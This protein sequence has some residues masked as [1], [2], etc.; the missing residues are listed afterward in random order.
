MSRRAAGPAAKNG[1]FAMT[2]IAGFIIAIVAG[3]I[4][5]D[6]RRAAAT[7]IIPWVAVLA[8]QTWI[9][10]AGRAVSPPGTVSHLPQAVGYWAVQAVF[11]ALALG[12]AWQLGAL[13]ARW[14]VPRGAAGGT[15]RRVAIA[16][17]LLATASAV[18]IVAWLLDSAPVRHHAAEGSPPV[19]GVVGMAL[20]IVTF[21]VLSV[22]TLRHRRA[23]ARARA[24]AAVPSTGLTAPG[25]RR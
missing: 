23:V 17:G 4:G 13:R 6:A 1:D 3:W 16:S 11:L 7:V 25:A 8:A 5:R 20:C 18:F 24:A 9:I 2:P 14:A 10:A 21:A 19:P 15:G 22:R 12:I